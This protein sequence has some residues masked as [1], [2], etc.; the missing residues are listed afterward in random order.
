MNFAAD[1]TR[2]AL[3]ALLMAALA[4]SLPGGATTETP[5]AAGALQTAAAATIAAQLGGSPTP[6]GDG[7]AEAS[8]SATQPPPTVVPSDTPGV[9]RIHVSVATNCRYG[10]GVVYDPPV[11][12]FNVGQTANVLGRD[13]GGNFYYIDQGC[14]VWE[15]Y[16]TVE[17]G[18]IGGVPVLTAPPTPTPA[19]IDPWDG[20]W[21]TSCASG[22]PCGD[23]IL[24][25]DGDDVT[26]SYADGEGEINGT[27]DGRHF[28]GTWERGGGS[29]SIDW[30]M[31]PNELRFRG[32]YNQTSGWC[33]AREGT[34]LPAV[35]GVASFYGTWTTQCAVPGCDT[36]VLEQ[37]GLN[38]S[39]TYYNGA[40][41]IEGTVDGLVLTG[42]WSYGNTSGEFVFYMLTNGEQFN[43]SYATG[44]QQWCGHRDG[45]GFP[46]P[47][48]KP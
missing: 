44:T 35:C 29:G 11:S 25:Q 20:L 12:I 27:V 43:G 2:L 26:G 3:A 34:S 36:M 16:V 14:W 10:P 17:A 46:N 13:S 39:G 18:N 9:P 23:V 32:N 33:G 40:R 38:V 7:A 22:S 15:N 5:D 19:Q 24:V 37:D 41:N 47:C 28:T 1:K 6:G 21:H 30:W 42:E 48:L 4:C 31:T 45:A 8:P